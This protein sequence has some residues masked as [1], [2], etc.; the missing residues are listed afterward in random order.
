MAFSVSLAPLLTSMGALGR[1]NRLRISSTIF[2]CH[3]VF[4]PTNNNVPEFWF[5][6]L[7]EG[8]FNVIGLM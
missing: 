2:F 7:V 3:F 1:C 4:L 8:M 6:I 5:A